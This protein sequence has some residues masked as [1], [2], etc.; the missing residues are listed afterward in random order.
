MGTL[1]SGHRVARARPEI[2][3]I[4]RA[5]GTHPNA[6]LCMIGALAGDVYTVRTTALAHRPQTIDEREVY[7]CPRT[8][9]AALCSLSASFS[10]SLGV[11]EVGG[12][13]EGI[14][15]LDTSVSDGRS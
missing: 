7:G 8:Q 1:D 12:F 5:N 15:D 11:R 13:W 14:R 6:A 2:R 4:L 9:I 3:H 10:V